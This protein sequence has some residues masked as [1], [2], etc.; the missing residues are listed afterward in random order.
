MEYLVNNLEETQEIAKKFVASLK[1]GEVIGLI[2]DL[3]AGKT[4]FVQFLA[5]SLGIKE[6]VNSPTFVL[7]KVYQT[8]NTQIKTLVHVDAYRLSHSEELK[9]IGL[10]EYFNQPDSIVVIEWADRV[11]DILPNNAVMIKIKEGNSDG[12]REFVVNFKI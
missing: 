6:K 9:N 4:T 11:V 12:A 10:E 3:G 1:G 5:S 8:S 7:M 2:G